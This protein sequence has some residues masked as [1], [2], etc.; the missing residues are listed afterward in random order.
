MGSDQSQPW[1]SLHQRGNQTIGRRPTGLCEDLKQ[2][3]QR[4]VK[5]VNTSTSG[6]LGLQMVQYLSHNEREPQLL[7]N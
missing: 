6:N 3:G 5:G 1:S 7:Q 2:R 4:D